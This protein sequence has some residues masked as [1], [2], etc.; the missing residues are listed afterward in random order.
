M[1][2]GSAFWRSAWWTSRARGGL[3]CGKL[4]GPFKHR[5]IIIHSRLEHSM[6]ASQTVPIAGPRLPVFLVKIE[7]S[8][9]GQYR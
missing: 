1:G 6:N 7:H 3:A 2:L 8:Q 4:T 9:A 5:T